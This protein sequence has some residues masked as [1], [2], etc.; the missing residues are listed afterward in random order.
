MRS[1]SVRRGDTFLP[2]SGLPQDAIVAVLRRAGRY[3][4]ILRGPDVILPHYWAPLSGR[5]EPWEDQA[6]AVVREVRE[7]VGLRAVPRRKVWECESDEGAFLLHWWLAEAG[8]GDLLL[9]PTEVS[10]ARW[11]TPEEFLRLEPTFEADRE[12]FEHVLPGV[13][14]AVRFHPLGE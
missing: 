4:I 13:P 5:V 14:E 11:L 8:P 9:D 3:L 1:R 10:E 7:E 2:S 6:D 12:F